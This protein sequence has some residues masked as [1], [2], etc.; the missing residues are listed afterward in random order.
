MAEY[1]GLREFARR[2]GIHAST[3]EDAM[4]KGRISTHIVDGKKRIDWETAEKEFEDNRMGA[5]PKESEDEPES[6]GKSG[7]PTFAESKAK[8][9][10]YNAQIAKLEWLEKKGKLINAEEVERQA[11][12]ETRRVRDAFLDLGLRLAPEL[13][14]MTEIMDVEKALDDAVREILETLSDFKP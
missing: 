3:V 5:N 2:K 8:R 6:G 10:A 12:E 1:I 11:V 4:K 14:A 13:V 7:V 9:E